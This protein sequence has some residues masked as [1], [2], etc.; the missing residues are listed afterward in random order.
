MKLIIVREYSFVADSWVDFPR[1]MSIKMAQ[2]AEIIDMRCIGCHVSLWAEESYLGIDGQVELVDREF[3]FYQINRP[4]QQP[5]PLLFK[6]WGVFG[7]ATNK[8]VLY[9]RLEEK[10]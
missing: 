10:Q 2:D 6:R 9:E 1:R 8:C 5:S 7:E 4:Y 3:V